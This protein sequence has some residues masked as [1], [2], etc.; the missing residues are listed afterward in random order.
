MFECT[1]TLQSL[2][3]Q[4]MKSQQTCQ[5]QEGHRKRLVFPVMWPNRPQDLVSPSLSSPK[6]ELFWARIV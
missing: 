1:S 6:K 3:Q 5:N 4:T 2:S